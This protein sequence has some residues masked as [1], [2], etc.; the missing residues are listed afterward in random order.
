MTEVARPRRRAA[1]A[2]LPVS[3]TA[4]KTAIWSRVGALGSTMRSTIQ[5]YRTIRSKLSQFSEQ[6]Q[7]PIFSL[8]IST[9][10]SDGQSPQSPDPLLF[11]L[12]HRRGP[13][14][15]GGGRGRGGGRRSP[16]APRPRVG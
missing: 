1:A 5:L 16:P 6:G 7:M 12:R 10:D 4:R 11:P 3:A 2:K 13:G 8:E 9:G 15:G 14:Q